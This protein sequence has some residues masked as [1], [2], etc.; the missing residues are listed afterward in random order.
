MLYR[1]GKHYP[2]QT[3]ITPPLKLYV[4]SPD[5]TSFKALNLLGSGNEIKPMSKGTGQPLVQGEAE[6]VP[7]ATTSETHGTD[8]LRQRRKEYILLG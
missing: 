3:G 4:R 1:Q 2:F 8:L 5:L 6:D 7:A